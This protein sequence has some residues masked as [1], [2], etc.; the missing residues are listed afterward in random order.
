MHP[1]H[2][3][4]CQ[5]HERRGK[6]EHD[7]VVLAGQVDQETNSLGTSYRGDIGREVIQTG[8]SADASITPNVV[9]HGQGIDV[10]QRPEEAG[11]DEEN[12]QHYLAGNHQPVKEQ[13][14]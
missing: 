3:E 10:D 11:G 9:N 2:Q 14:C 5:E 8:K 1:G 7:A 4:A 12:D 13:E 6:D